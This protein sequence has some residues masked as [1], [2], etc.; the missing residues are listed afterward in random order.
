MTPLEEEICKLNLIWCR[1]VGLDHSKG[2]DRLWYVTQEF[3]YG[4]MFFKATHWGYIANDFEGTKC[5]TL[6]EAQEELRDTLLL[7]IHKSKEWV[8][9]NLKEAQEDPDSWYDPKEYERMLHVL[10]GGEPYELT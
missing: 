6:E 2:K 7:E 8:S 3:S 1:F 10:N 9:R 5:T 4:E